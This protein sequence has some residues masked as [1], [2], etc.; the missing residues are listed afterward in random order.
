MVKMMGVIVWKITIKFNNMIALQSIKYLIWDYCLTKLFEGFHKNL[1]LNP[2]IEGR[3]PVH[4]HEIY[5]GRHLSMI[6]FDSGIFD[7]FLI[8]KNCIIKSMEPEYHFEKENPLDETK[9]TLLGFRIGFNYETINDKVPYFISRDQFL[10]CASES[11]R[12]Q[13]YI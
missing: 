2:N 10:F 9:I 8:Y 7:A 4:L 13:F 1:I 12:V 5:V 11:D 6:T 3:T